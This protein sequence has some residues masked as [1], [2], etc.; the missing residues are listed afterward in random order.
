MDNRIYIGVDLGTSFIKAGA[1]R[2]DGVQVAESSAPVKDERPAPGV[3]IQRGDFLYDAAVN[4]LRDVARAL[5]EDAS[6]V[7][8][9]AFTG[10]MA[11]SMGVGDNWEDITTWSCTLDSRFTPYAAD[12]RERFGEDMFTIGGTSAPVMCSKYAWFRNEFPEEHKKIRKYIMLNGY[13]IGRLSDIPVEE[14]IIDYSLI[15]WTGM[16][17]IKNRT[18]SQKICDEIGMEPSML[19]K[20]VSPDTIGGH[21]SRKAAELTGLPAGIPLVAGAGDKVAGCTGAGIF[22]EGEMIFEAAS[23]GAISVNV[24]DARLNPATRNYDVIGAVDD[25]SYY[26]HKYIQGSGI[27]TDWFV[28]TFFRD[29]GLGKKEAFAKAEA[30]AE[31]IGVGSDHLMAIGLLGGS[32]IPFDKDLKGMFLGHTWTHHAGHFYHAL[33]ESFSYDLALTLGSIQELYPQYADRKIKLIGGGAKS[34]F[35]PQMLA[36]VTGHTFQQIN[37]KDVAMWGAALIAAK[38]VGEIED[39]EGFSKQF[40]QVTNEF[41]PDPERNREYQR[42]I[43]FYGK[44]LGLSS[45][46]FTELEAL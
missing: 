12:Q 21:L 1:Y 23:Y 40:I 18:W 30:L 29:Q 14:A 2:L 34:S 25:Q 3:F 36:D 44:L 19:P 26:L 17:D 32:S 37:R 7:A 22:D 43:E 35:W 41:V 20:V 38:A 15:T 8:A 33:M 24:R 45:G 39:L 4:C 6:R 27:S 13:L 46:I 5:G 11:G 28:N 9:I 16:S 31:N 10:Q 42:Y